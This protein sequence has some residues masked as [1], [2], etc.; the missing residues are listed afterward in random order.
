M[1]D[2][3]DLAPAGGKDFRLRLAGGRCDRPYFMRR[4]S[5]WAS[6]AANAHVLTSLSQDQTADL[7][8]ADIGDWHRA[9][10]DQVEMVAAR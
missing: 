5:R 9:E 1:A 6:R 3:E 7:L 4:A 8:N 2:G 10:S